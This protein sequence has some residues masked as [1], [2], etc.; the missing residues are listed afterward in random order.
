MLLS[1]EPAPVRVLAANVVAAPDASWLYSLETVSTLIA[2]AELAL[3]VEA[4]LKLVSTKFPYSIRKFSSLERLFN[5]SLRS[6]TALRLSQ[7][8]TVRFI[9]ASRSWVAGS[10]GLDNA[11]CKAVYWAN[12]ITV[13]LPSLLASNLGPIPSREKTRVSSYNDCMNG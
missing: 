2:D 10:F 6:I 9:A 4:M 5:C 8:A 3:L 7:N 1:F 13:T 11:C 12:S